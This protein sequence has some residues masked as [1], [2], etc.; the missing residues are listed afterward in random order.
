MAV[1]LKEIKSLLPV[2]GVKLG[3]AAAGIRYP[4]R[5]D[6][7]LVEL[8]AGSTTAAIFTRNAFCAAPVSIA[9]SN[10]QQASPKYFLINAGNAN[11]GTGEPGMQAA[12]ECCT[13]VAAMM[14][15]SAHEVLPFSTG[16]I[17]EQL[18]VDKIIH[19]LP[20]L[21]SGLKANNWLPAAQ[22]IMTTDTMAKGCSEQFVVGDGVDGKTITITGIV[23]G[24]GM[25]CPNMATLLS[26]IATDAQIDQTILDDCLQGT[27]AQSFNS[28]T[29]D[30][31][32]ST[33]DACTLT[34]TGTSGVKIQSGKNLHK[35]QSKLL[36]VIQSLAQAV[37]RDAE[38]A[39]K[40]VSVVV[41]EANDLSEARAV[42]YTVAQSPLVKTALY[43]SDPNWG[44][45]LAAVGRA[46]LDSLDISRVSLYLADTRLISQ[47][48]PDKN[49]TEEQGQA[50]MN[51]EEITI[52]I[53]L[54]R[55][56]VSATIWTSDLSQEYVSI[57]AD[58]RS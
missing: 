3:A 40:F 26:F 23:K 41:E 13:A 6:L 53:K 44:R 12:R 2:K 34:A 21:Q 56:D 20:D 27:V 39:T 51:K 8:C 37:I 57:N 7:V 29:V 52:R 54:G 1:G 17:G 9:I 49:Y 38:G 46:P 25:I 10:K 14:Q 22:A 33:N 55:G 45:I 42:A 32:T 30:G 19:A 5:N 35:F 50:E 11:A 47:G 48:E 28:I 4:N 16:V 18:P 31:D 15:T 36:S 43:A 24:S 58:Y